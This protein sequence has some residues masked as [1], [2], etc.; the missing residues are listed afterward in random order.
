MTISER[1]FQLWAV[2][3]LSS[4]KR[5]ILSYKELSQLVGVFTADI[6]KYL[7]PIQSFC[8]LKKL[9]PL[10]AIVVG[11]QSGIPG[12]GF[13][14]ASDVPN[15]QAKVFLYDWY[16]IHPSISDLETAVKIL[17]SNGRSLPELLEQIKKGKKPS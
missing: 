10:S 11:V 14:A 15:A 9:P 12:K 3:A 2:L 4:T 6:G 8:I 13:I 5:Q 7:E 17:P 16:K 1:A